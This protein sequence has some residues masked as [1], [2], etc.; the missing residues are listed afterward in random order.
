MSKLL[1]FFTIAN[2]G[3]TFTISASPAQ[4]PAG[5]A[6]VVTT[7]EFTFIYSYYQLLM[8]NIELKETI[9]RP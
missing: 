9:K 8:A 7:L 5:A 1:I 3:L 6:F 4:C 2:I